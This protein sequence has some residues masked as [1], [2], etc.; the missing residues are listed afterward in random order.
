M[1]IKW[2]YLS[3]MFATAPSYSAQ[4]HKCEIDGVVTFSQMPCPDN[5]YKKEKITVKTQPKIQAAKNF[6]ADELKQNTTSPLP[7]TSNNSAAKKDLIRVSIFQLDQQ[8]ARRNQNIQRLKRKMS[9]SVSKLKTRTTYANNNLAGAIYQDALSEEMI[10]TTNKY[11]TMIHD[12]ERQIEELKA[13]KQTLLD[14]L[15]N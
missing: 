1:K 5:A 3:L 10:A 15:N 4:I 13:K 8:I 7:V 14:Q 12:E 2:I 6:N 9:R 11:A